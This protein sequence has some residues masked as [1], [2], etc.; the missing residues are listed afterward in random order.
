VN[1]RQDS[2]RAILLDLD[3]TLL[4][5]DMERFLPP[6][7]AALGRR[8]A[9]FVAPGDLVKML[10]ASTRVMMQNDDPAITNQQAFD[11]DFFPRLGHPSASVRP[12]IAAF[13]EEDFPALKCHTHTRPQARPLVQ[14]LFDQGFDVVIATNPMFPRRAIEH[15]LDCASVRDFTFKLVT[16]YENSHFCKPNPHYY[17]E[18][19]GRLGCRPDQAMMVGDDLSNDI[20]PAAQV[21]LHTYWIVESPAQA[22]LASYAERHGSL[23]DCLAWVQSG[24]LKSS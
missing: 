5:N 1:S 17:E 19:L 12:V 23:A 3:D 21:G 11:A 8:L 6:Y 22:G 10:L 24:A 9:R 16:S 20:E 18:I 15:R 2:L 14:A 4:G 7:F 13:Y